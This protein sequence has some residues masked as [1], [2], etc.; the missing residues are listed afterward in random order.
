M[1]FVIQLA[2]LAVFQTDNLI[3]A[4][5]LGAKAVTPYSVT[6]RL[7]SYTTIFQMLAG[8][9]FWPAYAEAFARGDKAWVRR[10][11]RTNFAISIGS[12]LVLGVPLVLFGQRMIANW[13]GSEAV[14]TLG[15]LLWMGVWSVI[16]AAMSFQAIVLASCGRLKTQMTYSIAAAAVNLA[17]SVVLIQ[18]IGLTG[19]ILG[20]IIAFLTCILIPQWVETERAI[21]G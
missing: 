12:T 7:F 16:S 21:G 1:F 18:R 10:S 14:P 20:T 15:L 6:L 4:H 8:P 5:F 9:S 3:I 2:A 17:L 19:V 11:F 13:A